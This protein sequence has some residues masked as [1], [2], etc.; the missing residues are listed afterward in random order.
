MLFQIV[1]THT[2]ENCPAGS[3]EKLK[4]ISAWWQG[5]KNTAGVK[6]LSGYVSPLDHTFWI[7]VEAVDYATLAKSLGPLMSIGTGHIVPVLALDQ[8]IP[9]AETGAFRAR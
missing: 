4:P 1:H 2:A 9:I 7:A 8:S 6:V 5:L 3:Q